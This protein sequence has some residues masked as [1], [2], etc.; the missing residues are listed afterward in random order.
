M[1]FNHP[2]DEL[3]HQAFW[4][5]NVSFIPIIWQLN[6]CSDRVFRV[7]C[8]ATEV[9]VCDLGTYLRH[10]AAPLLYLKQLAYNESLNIHNKVDLPL[11]SS[12]CMLYP[13]N[14]GCCL[15]GDSSLWIHCWTCC[16]YSI[17]ILMEC[18]RIVESKSWSPFPYGSDILS[19]V[20]RCVSP[21]ACMHAHHLQDIKSAVAFTASRKTF[22]AYLWSVCL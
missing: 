3:L 8:I 22:R 14:G 12:L 15:G 10:I 20:S 17:L 1:H 18:I 13:N 9:D 7:Q 16:G 21:Y 2:W 19:I 11:Q 6:K 5:L 4:F